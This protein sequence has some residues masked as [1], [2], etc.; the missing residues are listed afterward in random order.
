MDKRRITTW[1]AR[2]VVNPPARLVAGRVP[3][4]ALLETTGRTS[5]RPR[6]TPVTDGLDGDTFWIVAEHGHRADYVRNLEKDP[7]VRVRVRGRWRTGTAH[8]LPAQD[9]RDRLRHVARRGPLS[10]LN[11]SMVRLVGTDLTVV[12]IDLEP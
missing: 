9:V 4:F 7:R 8:V 6:H 10:R 12:R 3:G 2:R 11:A 1:V 5:G